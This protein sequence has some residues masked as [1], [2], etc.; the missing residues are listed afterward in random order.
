ME[1][2]EEE[3]EETTKNRLSSTSRNQSIKVVDDDEEDEGDS[4]DFEQQ[5]EQ[6]EEEQDEEQDEEEQD[7]E[8]EQEEGKDGQTEVE[9]P[10]G[11]ENDTD[12][13]RETTL[14]TVRKT[15]GSKMLLNLLSDGSS[16]KKLTEE[17][18]QLRR[19]ENA[20]KRKNLS[21]KRSEEEKREVLDKLLKRRAAKSRSHLPNDDENS[22]DGT[23]ESLS[24]I[25]PRRP[26]SSPGMIRTLRKAETDL[27]CTY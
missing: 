6:E 26:Y 1:E 10:S 4:E 3:E 27:Y 14:E 24:Y 15:G 5:E 2:E 25:K 12:G 8:Q 21:E 22:K 13:S 16:R 23:D 17:E 19:A 9:T 20:R 7:E 18:I 11:L